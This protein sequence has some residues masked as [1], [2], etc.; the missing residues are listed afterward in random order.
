MRACATHT[1]TTSSCSAASPWAGLPTPPPA[2]RDIGGV[3]MV[4]EAT[5]DD[6]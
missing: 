6:R 4:D 1:H 2:S 5:A 3:V